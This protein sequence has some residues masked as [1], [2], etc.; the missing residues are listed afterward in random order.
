MSKRDEDND[1]FHL[2]VSYICSDAWGEKKWDE[3]YY[4]LVRTDS[5]PRLINICNAMRYRYRVDGGNG[6]DCQVV[7]G[8]YKF[9]EDEHV[10][11]IL[12]RGN[13]IVLGVDDIN[14]ESVKQDTYTDNELFGLECHLD[15]IYD[16]ED[17]E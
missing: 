10:V 5:L 4:S 8:R 17:S 6:R 12:Y 11:T 13:G 9:C 7:I 3:G 14:L 2:H 15:E 1:V 16:V